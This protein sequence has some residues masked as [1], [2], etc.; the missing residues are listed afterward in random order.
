MDRYERTINVVKALNLFNNGELENHKFLSYVNEYFDFIKNENLDDAD[1]KFLMYLSNRAGIPHY[2]DIL[3]NFNNQNTLKIEDEEIGL[4]TVSSLIYES[5]LYTDN[6]SKLHQFQKEI[7]D[8]FESD[9][10]N[11]YFLSASTSFGKTHL[12]YEVIKKIQYKN[13]ALIFPSIAL[14]SENL[15][16]IKEGRIE[17]PQNYEIHTLSDLESNYG[18]YNIFIFTPE[19]FLSFLDKKNND[20]ELDF[21]FIDE[22]YKID[23]GYIIDNEAKENERDV[24]Y[25]MSI[26]YGLSKF[27]TIDILLAGPY[28]EILNEK[29]E[30]YNPSFDLFLKDL[31]IEKLLRNKY[32]IVKV[33]QT[34]IEKENKEITVDGIIFDFR[35]KKSKK[36]KIQELLDR[37]LV[38]NENAIIYC[39]TKAI[40]EKVASEYNRSGIDTDYYQAFL[41]HLKSTYDNEWIVIN[42]LEKGIGVHHGV[43]PK[44]IQK[45]IVSLFNDPNSNIRIL[46]STTTITE[47]VNTTAKNMI[48]YKS[49]KGS[50]QYSKPLLTFD[51]KNIAGRAGR[52]MEHYTG[53]V[54][55]LD[56]DFINKLNQIGEPITHKN[57]DPNQ[58]KK[59]ID[60]EM[61]P[62]EFLDDRSKNRLL[63]VLRMQE[64]RGIPDDIIS[65]F[66]V[67]SRRNKIRIYDKIINLD[68]LQH[69]KV[70]KLIR[71][72]NG[73]NIGIDKDGFQVVIDLCLEIID[74]ENLKSLI[75]NKFKDNYTPNS[76]SILFASLNSYLRYGFDGVYKYYLRKERKGGNKNAVNSAMRQASS[77]IFNTFKY[78][79]VKYL[80]IFNLM[81]KFIESRKENVDFE[82]ISGIDKLLIK[83]EYNAFSEEARIAS[84]FGVPEKIVNYYDSNNP[85]ESKKILDE[86]D[87]YEITVF[88]RIRRI[89]EE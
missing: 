1:K 17:F 5:S 80:G 79:L 45:E 82:D 39:N 35:N 38:Q 9:K 87:S 11:R 8:L 61:T 53:R 78:Q 20:L 69:L 86:F 21:I 47:G 52:F 48:V 34:N 74:N 59:E 76:Y 16:K 26:F 23:N 40:T 18:D 22:V 24:A 85:S 25:R 58:V 15:A 60:D 54:I 29:S 57:Y 41:D 88:N 46:C 36:L 13:I 3:P 7:L 71:R 14:L 4:S 12:V 19:R 62:N 66:K 68:S 28:I 73:P 55:S 32:E 84:D 30:N 37:I 31:N 89:I 75:E 6:N 33:S 77:L 63:E 27:P 2:Y 64:E 43:V 56:T 72:L 50:G 51:A 83:L 70:N 42:S 81:Y 67:V 65:Q 10:P 49:L 44:Y